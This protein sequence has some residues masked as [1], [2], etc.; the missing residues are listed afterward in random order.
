VVLRQ[1]FRQRAGGAFPRYT[2]AKTEGVNDK[3]TTHLRHIR[4]ERLLGDHV[5]DEDGEERVREPR[6]ARAQLAYVVEEGLAARAGRVGEEVGGLPHLGRVPEERERLGAEARRERCDDLQ[7][8]RRRGV[9]DGRVEDERGGARRRR[10]GG[11]GGGRRAGGRRAVGD[12]RARGDAARQRRGRACG[13][14]RRS[15]APGGR[16]HGRAGLQGAAAAGVGAGA[17]GSVQGIAARSCALRDLEPSA[18]SAP[19]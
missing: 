11:R 18:S 10:G 12:G 2:E 1:Q 16:R 13:Q 8:A 4:R 9:E 17:R 14:R 6:R 3:N 5:A 15:G 7:L 19:L